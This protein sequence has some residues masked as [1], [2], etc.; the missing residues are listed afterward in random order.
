M[1]MT[2]SVPLHLLS[3]FFVYLVAD[4]IMLSSFAAALGAA[5]NSPQETR[6]IWRWCWWRPS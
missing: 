1:A 3:W 2:G 4:V 5:C 6:R